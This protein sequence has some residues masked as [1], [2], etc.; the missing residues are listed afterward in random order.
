MVDIVYMD[1]IAS[2]DM[3]NRDLVKIVKNLM[4]YQSN[5]SRLKR[6]VSRDIIEI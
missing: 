5:Q 4:V 2:F 3:N 1:Y 6:K